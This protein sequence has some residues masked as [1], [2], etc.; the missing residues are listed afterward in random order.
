M[1]SEM[2]WCNVLQRTGSDFCATN[3]F[4]GIFAIFVS[5]YYP[6]KN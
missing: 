3:N 6:R 5:W 4:Q 2:S 1:I